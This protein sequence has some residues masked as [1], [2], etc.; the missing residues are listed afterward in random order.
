MKQYKNSVLFVFL[1]FCILLPLQLF[2]KMNLEEPYPSFIFP[3]FASLPIKEEKYIIFTKTSTQVYF[4][5]GRDTLLVT[6]DYLG[7]DIPRTIQ[8]TIIQ[9]LLF[10]KEYPVLDEKIN[11]LPAY[12][13]GLYLTKKTILNRNIKKVDKEE[14]KTFIIQKLRENFLGKDVSEILVINE[15]KEFDIT[16]KKLTD[17]VKQDTV[18][19]FKF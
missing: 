8:I 13:K 19:N 9:N 10:P 11:A 16:T 14:S 4:K 7:K 2:F 6:N 1:C 5:D 12:K 15:K 18:L 3:G 17:R